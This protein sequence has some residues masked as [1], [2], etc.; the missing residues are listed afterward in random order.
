MIENSASFNQKTEYSQEKYIK[1]KEGKSVKNIVF[2]A[3]LLTKKTYYIS[4]NKRIHLRY[5]PI[6][7]V[8]RPTIRTL[9]HYY[10]QGMNKRK[11]L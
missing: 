1:K 7:Q 2:K 10:T 5:L 6:Y 11:L 8:L 3:L 9:C 4:L